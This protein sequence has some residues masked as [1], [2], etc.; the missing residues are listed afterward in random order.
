M[1]VLS[2]T[3]GQTCNQF[4]QYLHYLKK[5][6]DENKK[7]Y[8]QMPD[9]TIEDYP[10]L[11]NNKY[12]GFPFY[13]KRLTQIIGLKNSLEFTR[14]ITVLFLNNYIRFFLHNLTFRKINFLSGKPTWG[15]KNNNYTSILPILRNLFD[16]K[17]NLKTAVDKIWIKEKGVINCGIH[18]RGG[19]YRKWKGGKYFFNQDVYALYMQRF[20]SFFPDKK[21]KFYIASNEPIE[22][23]AL[24]SINGGGN[25]EVIMLPNA[26]ATQ[27]LYALTKC[28]YIIGT[29]SSYN[30]WISLVWEIPLYTIL[31]REGYKNMTLQDFSKVVN[32]RFKA[33]GWEYP[34]ADDF[35][36][37]LAHPWLYRHSN[38]EHLLNISYD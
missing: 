31:E 38:K 15:L 18:I 10:N 8:V 27:D 19:D 4:W 5:G 9:K 24:T 1:N 11:L 33:N 34:R 23:C 6:I 29:L 3:Q 25:Y 16:L 35:Y 17:K 22:P 32:Y 2:E 12:I 30:S 37:S 14:K 20:L 7:L 13:S 21:V 36:T 26:T 28:D